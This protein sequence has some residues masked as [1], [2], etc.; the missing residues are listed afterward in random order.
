M[1][2]PESE[3]IESVEIAETYELI[4]ACESIVAP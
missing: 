3:A 4:H 1:L 2:I